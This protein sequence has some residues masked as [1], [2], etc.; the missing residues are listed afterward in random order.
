MM[1]KLISFGI[2]I[3]FMVVMAVAVYVVLDSIGSPVMKP[4]ASVINK[5]TNDGEA[6]T[7][8]GPYTTVKKINHYR[9][10]GDLELYSRGPAE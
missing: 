5:V 10:C 3:M 1:K 9:S 4:A 8:V 6:E 2:A 7:L